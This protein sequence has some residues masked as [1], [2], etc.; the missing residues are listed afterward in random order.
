MLSR[1][2]KEHQERQSTLREEQERKRK[3]A[4]ASVRK[5]THAMVDSLNSGVEKAYENQRKL[6]RE[7][8]ALQANSARYVK[9]T[10]QWLGLVEGFHKSLKSLG[11]LEQWAR[12][13]ETDMRM[14][15]DT[16]DY[17]YRGSGEVHAFHDHSDAPPPTDQR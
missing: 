1:M 14:V 3:A 2:V 7:A 15:V 11:D 9:Q 13:I 4:L 12:T 8:K 5:C 6:D 17:A 10:T 16:L